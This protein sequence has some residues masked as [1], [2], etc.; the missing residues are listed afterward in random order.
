M[1][2][3]QD[4][5]RALDINARYLGVAEETL[6]ENAGR[7]VAEEVL[8]RFGTEAKAVVLCGHGNNG[9]DG[10]VAARYLAEAGMEVRVYLVREPASELT[11]RMLAEL[12]STGMVKVLK[13]RGR[14]S[15]AD[16]LVD[17][18]LGTGVRGEVREPYRSVI[19]EVNRFAGY[20]VS[21]D[22]PSGMNES[23]GGYRVEPDL[24]VTLHAM[25]RGLENLPCVVRDI[26][27]PEEAGRYVGPGDVAVS[28]W[29]RSRDSHKGENGRVL[30]VG[31]STEYHGA[32]V[33]AALGA[34]R[35]GA[36]LVLVAVPEAIE[37]PVRA[38]SP[39]IILRPY[40]G[41]RLE[42]G[43]VD[44]LLELAES[45]D[46]VLL[47]PGLGEHE[48]T[49]DAVRHMLKELEVPCVLDASALAAARGAA[50]PEG[51]VL[52]PHAG[53]FRKITGTS[54]P[55]EVGL[56]AEAVQRL[57]RRRRAV[58]LLKGRVDVIASPG[59]VKL[60]RTGSPGMTKGGTGDVLAGVVAS[61]IAQ[62]C[63]SFEAA[64][65]AA[66]LCGLAGETLE[67]RRG[68]GFSA[69]EL[70][71]ALPEAVLSSLEF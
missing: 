39:E 51:S 2:L 13:Y 48:K 20:V 16:V 44:A 68:Y 42:A 14:L 7:A 28:V 59:R 55:R 31:G 26:G 15:E 69:A 19:A 54:L 21:V 40:S 36:D 60:N 29:K 35:A 50:L 23:G 11:A 27:I 41:Q 25:K 47:G 34:M 67:R 24:V 58:V 1:I 45:A 64:C 4:E 43:A 18:L 66:F 46:C 12:R 8:R 62:G 9:G 17:A 10:L 3:S 56:R 5:M 53:E 57:A 33:L 61:F 32:P 38:A 6:M 52:T 49:L 70:A 65:C 22:L 37:V 63:G 30:I 71:E